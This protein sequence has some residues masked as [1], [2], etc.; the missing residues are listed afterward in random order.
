[1]KQIYPFISKRLREH[2]VQLGLTQEKLA[3]RSR[4]ASKFISDLER[5][6]KKPSLETVFRLSKGLKIPLNEFFGDIIWIENP[7]KNKYVKEAE[8]LL[9]DCSEKEAK[10][11]LDILKA[12]LKT[13]PTKT[14]KNKKGTAWLI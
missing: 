3:E 9:L 13:N 4:I 11:A 8:I 10:K 2:R 6:K 1:M 12:Y 7:P 14:K 5:G